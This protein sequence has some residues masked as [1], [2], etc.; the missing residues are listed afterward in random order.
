MSRPAIVVEHVSKQYRIGLRAKGKRSLHETVTDVL[1]YPFRRFRALGGQMTEEDRFW[2]L[3]DV[4][5]EVPSGQV[6]G[7]IGANGAGKSTLL[8]ILS[9]ITE[10]TSGRALLSGRVASLLEV[11]SGFHRELTGRENIY[12]NGTILGMRKAEI[13][14]KFDEIVAFAE[15]EKFID[16]PVKRY[17]S[18]MHT[19]LAFA[20]AAHL[21]PEILL[22]D[23]VL[24]VGDASFQK[25]CL[26]KMSDVA[27]AGRTILFV[28]HNMAA[29]ESLCSRVILIED[30]R[31]VV[32]DEPDVGVSAYLQ[33]ARLA[34]AAEDVTYLDIPENAPRYAGS[35]PTIHSIRLLDREGVETNTFSAG[36]NMVV[37]FSF[38]GSKT[39]KPLGVGVGVDSLAHGRIASFNNM[40]QGTTRVPEAAA[41]GTVRF[42][43]PNIPF[44]PG[45]Y[46]LTPSVCAG[47]V[48]IVDVVDRCLR[49]TVLPRAAHGASQ[50]PMKGQGVVWLPAEIVYEPA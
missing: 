10:P 21:Q 16:T 28:S 27:K 40:I 48:Q 8:K 24:A 34:N 23:E 20:V 50:L 7:I 14:R 44:V 32:D 31:L 42:D 5:F 15:V 18:G 39:I 2:A 6:V 22:V 35:V 12:L 13:N 19:R 33:R 17:S 29:I 25:R 11:G 38:S 43:I 3:Q 26:G 1:A 47:S 4:S 46:Y 45:E 41:S 49:F 36:D 30:G 9:R 37:E